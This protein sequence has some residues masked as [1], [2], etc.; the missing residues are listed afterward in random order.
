M[1]KKSSKYKFNQKSQTPVE[2]S[3]ESSCT[4]E[5][6]RHSLM[7]G[8][9]M[10]RV[11]WRD[12]TAYSGWRRTHWMQNLIDGDADVALTE[13]RTV[14]WLLHEGEEKVVLCMSIG[15]DIDTFGEVL[16]IPSCNVKEIV[17]L[18]DG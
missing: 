15:A 8:A 2:P 1:S 17:E 6:A 4:E 14:A 11:T 18:V 13:F 5:D 12:I 10:V 7:S 16:V 3:D 9:R